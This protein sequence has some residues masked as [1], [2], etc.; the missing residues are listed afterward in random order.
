MP[1]RVGINGFGRIGR[2]V[3]RAA[4]ESRGGRRDRRRQRHHGRQDAR[5]PAQVRHGLRPVAEDVEARDGHHRRRPGV[6]VLAE[7]DPAALPWGDLDVDVVI[8]STGLFTKRDEAAKHL[9]GGREE[10]DH[11]GARHRAGRHRRARRQLRGGLRP[12]QP[13]RHLERVVHDRV[14]RAGGQGAARCDR[15]RARPD[16]DDPRLHRRPE[17]PGRAAQGPAPCAGGGRE[18]RPGV[19][20]R[21]EGDRDRDPR[22][23]GQVARLRDAGARADRLGRRPHPR[24]IARRPRS[25]RSTRRCASRP[26]PAP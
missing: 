21:R 15:H 1:V 13:P 5:A 8:E 6:K 17:P 14:P 16:D 7:R 24:P 2:N 26:T 4:L 9:E 25:T 20:R 18:P 23:P 10:G 12:G 22:A 3:F 11:L 19:D